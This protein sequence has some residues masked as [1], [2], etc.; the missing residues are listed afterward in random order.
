[1]AS[2]G[3]APSARGRSRRCA[4]RGAP[5]RHPRHPRP[6]QQ[7]R[8]PPAHEP[9]AQYQDQKKPHRQYQVPS[10]LPCQGNVIKSWNM[11]C[12]Q[13]YMGGPAPRQPRLRSA[14]ARAGQRG[15]GQ[16]A[17]RT[18]AG[19]SRALPPGPVLRGDGT[20]SHEQHPKWRSVHRCRAFHA[21]TSVYMRL[22]RPI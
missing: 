15:R 2:L 1:M 22:P 17:G 16:S 14:Q 19:C 3:A 8:R 20:A 13:W 10:W 6:L 18:R 11:C 4:A 5:A 12:E 9:E 21:E 7:P